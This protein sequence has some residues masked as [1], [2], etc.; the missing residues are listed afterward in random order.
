MQLVLGRPVLALQLERMS[1]ARLA[2]KIVVATTELA[3]DDPVASLSESLGFSVY[4]GH[5]TNLLDRHYRAALSFSPD[6]VVKIPSDCPLIDPAVMDKVIGAFLASPCDYYSNLHP[7]SYPDG[8]DV[9]AISFSALH[10]AWREASKAFELE[11]TT[12]FIW[13]R[14]NRFSIRNVAWE[15]GQDFSMSHRFTLD[16]SQDLEFLRAVFAGLYPG[17]PHF[18]LE[19]ILSFLQ[20]RPQV[21]H[22][23]Q[24]FAGVNWYRNHLDELKTVSALETRMPTTRMGGSP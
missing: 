2:G 5:A 19:D 6:V 12:P 4:R 15:K 9:E 14:P 23:N 21:F 18:G 1:R 8:N 11:H 22:L 10:D 13:E 24:E 16:Y 20:E 17:N 7:A 3:E